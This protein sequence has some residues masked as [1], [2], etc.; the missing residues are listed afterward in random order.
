M[1]YSVYTVCISRIWLI[2]VPHAHW[3]NGHISRWTYISR[4]PHW[5]SLSIYYK[6]VYAVRTGSVFICTLIY[7]LHI[8][9]IVF[10]QC[11]VPSFHTVCRQTLFTCHRTVAFGMIVTVWRGCFYV[12]WPPFSSQGSGLGRWCIMS[13]YWCTVWMNVV[14]KCQVLQYYMKF[15]YPQWRRCNAKEYLFV[16][17]RSDQMCVNNG[18]LRHSVGY[19]CVLNVNHVLCAVTV[20]KLLW[21]T[22]LNGWRKAV[23]LRSVVSHCHFI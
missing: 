8:P 6:I 18:E 5:F 1:K 23:M 15:N 16:T 4:L 22:R 9:G 14:N 21:L 12:V 13:A 7:I 20:P 2:H 17:T 10:L 3:F 11:P 19:A